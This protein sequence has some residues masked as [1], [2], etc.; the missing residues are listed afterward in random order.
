MSGHDST[1]RDSGPSVLVQTEDGTNRPAGGDNDVAGV[2]L[3]RWLFR[4]FY[5][6]TV[7]LI[8]ILLMALL[9]V[10]GSV[11]M[12]AGPGTYDDPAKLESFLAAARENYGGWAPILDA[13]GLF[14]VFTSLGFYAVVAM[15]AL[16]I[17][18]CT[19]HRI[20]ELWRRVRH[21]RVHVVPKFFDKARY[22]GTAPTA[23]GRKESLDIVGG[24]LRRH[25]FRVLVD[26][27]DPEHSLHADRNAWS[28][29]GT[30]V[31][32][33]SFIIILLAFVISSTWA[34]EEDLAVP[35]GREVEVGYGTGLTL[36]ATSFKDSYTEEG[37]PSDYVS[38]LEL[39]R[40]DEVVAAQ[41]V[42]VNS[43][44]EYGGFRYHQ[45]SFGIAADVTVRDAAGKVHFDESVPMRWSSQEGANAVGLFE[46][47]GSEYE[48]VVVTA[49][50]GRTNSSVPAGTALF[51][52]YPLGTQTGE[53]LEVRLANQGQDVDIAEYSFTFERERQYTGIRMRQDPG[54]PWMWVGSTLLVAGMCV[55]FMFQYR[56]MWIRVDD[57][58][59]GEP[60][61][62]R[63]GAVSRLDT[64]YQRLFENIVAEV[65]DELHDATVQTEE[66]SRGQRA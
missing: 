29:V 50:S 32:H 25:R 46:L 66:E 47:P 38:E 26:G 16:S 28:G 1:V 54:T 23:L 59:A 21:P 36:H 52:L 14:H 19:T 12:Q 9:A 27:K 3:F 24:V 34:I 11:I 37:R 64:S 65:D 35:I 40:G 31:A 61:R 10:L 44:L 43:P 13:L 45:S 51:E 48:V 20:P 41:E 58:V 49:A 4:F 33:L 55:T 5:S 6:K 15:L 8:L 17:M 7:G 30:V 2:E 18:A 53:P 63:F 42:R 39:R 22:R 62:V 60:G 56:R 57:G